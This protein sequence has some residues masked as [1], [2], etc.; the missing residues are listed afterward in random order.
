MQWEISEAFG[1]GC[2]DWES[3]CQ[4]S[5]ALRT[6]T[7]LTAQDVATRYTREGF[8]DTVPVC[9]SVGIKYSSPSTMCLWISCM[10]CKS[11]FQHIWWSIYFLPSEGF[12]WGVILRVWTSSVSCQDLN[13]S[14]VKGLESQIC[15]WVNSPG[16]YSVKCLGV[17][18]SP[19]LADVIHS[20]VSRRTEGI[21]V[22]KRVVWYLQCP[23]LTW[24]FSL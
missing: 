23:P 20:P 24:E 4:C 11:L 9:S 16:H 7:G 6:I 13:H 3:V 2:K 8:C 22:Q 21:C 18:P 10:L 5:S 1:Y 12:F 19:V 17:M 15:F 14:Q